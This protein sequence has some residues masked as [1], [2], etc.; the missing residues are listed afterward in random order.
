MPVCRPASPSRPLGVR[1]ERYEAV[2]GDTAPLGPGSG[3]DR[4]G[5]VRL[6]RNARQRPS[7]RRSHLRPNESSRY[8]TT[9]QSDILRPKP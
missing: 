1:V 7:C 9:I 3:N 8:K 5:M 2:V 4:H 6:W